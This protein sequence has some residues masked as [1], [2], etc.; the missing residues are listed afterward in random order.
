MQR[1]VVLQRLC[2]VDCPDD[3]RFADILGPD[4]ALLFGEV[5]A[6]ELCKLDR[7][8]LLFL[9]LGIGPFALIR[10]AP[11]DANYQVDDVLRLVLD[12]LTHGVR[13]V[14]GCLT[15]LV[16]RYANDLKIRASSILVGLSKEYDRI[17]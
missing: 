14:L 2:S 5:L 6:I 16:F 7:K 15:E 17:T 3:L 9:R 1:S 11:H 8:F 13:A 4:P 10:I 12:E